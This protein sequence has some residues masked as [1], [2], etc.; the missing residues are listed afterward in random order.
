MTL[1]NLI[2]EVIDVTVSLGNATKTKKLK[3]CK[4]NTR[5]ILFIEIDKTL[6]IN[7]FYKFP[8]KQ[9]LR[10]IDNL[11]TPILE[12]NNNVMPKKWESSWD[13]IGT[14]TPGGNTY[15]QKHF[16]NH[17]KGWAPTLTKF[18]ANSQFS[19]TTNSRAKFPMV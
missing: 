7:T 6:R 9:I 2:G 10:L 13:S 16:S 14:T 17:S 18:K 8:V 11:E 1:E 4:I 5:T 19:S 3:V 15:G 12:F